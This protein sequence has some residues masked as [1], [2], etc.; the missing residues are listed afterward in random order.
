MK[1]TLSLILTLALLLAL[2]P[3]AFADDGDGAF[4]DVP[5]DHWAYNDV[6][7]AAS[8]GFING[9]GD[10]RFGPNDTLTREQWAALIVRTLG[11]RAD[12]GVYCRA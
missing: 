7:E 6:T 4:T 1:K 10:G 5:A 3:A 12:R 2:A 8:L 9:Y 11:P